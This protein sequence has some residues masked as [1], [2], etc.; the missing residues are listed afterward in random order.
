MPLIYDLI[1]PQDLQGFVRNLEFPEFALGQFLPQRDVAD[2]E[3]RF[4]R[5]GLIDQDVAPFRSFD[6]ESPIGRRQGITRVTGELP[7][8]SKKIRLGEEQRLRMEALRS[9]DN[10]GLVAQIYDDA[11]QMARSVQA[12]LEQARGQALVEGQVVLNENG[13]QATVNFGRAGG[14]TVAPATLWS[15]TANSDPVAD[16][17]GWIETYVNTNGVAPGRILTS[18]AVVSNLLKNAKIRNY[19]ATVLGAPQRVSR[20]ALDQTLT[21]YALPAI[22]TYDVSVRV[23]GVA[24]RVIPADRV[25]LLPPDGETLG[26]TLFGVTAEALE[27]RAAGVIVRE[28]EPGITAVVDRTTDPVATWTKA[29]AIALPVV[30]NPDLTLVADVQ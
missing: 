1:D 11:A 12:R 21:D 22:E 25:I 20:A 7:P 2:L 6:T 26:A 15:D 8:I 13:V 24:T 30:G 18:T 23:N 29:A 16:L 5:N 27:L 10:S 4:I 28:Q 14:H 3:Y 19:A 9:G 17:M